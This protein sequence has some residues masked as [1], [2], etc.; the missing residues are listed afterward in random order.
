LVTGVRSNRE[1]PEV[2]S[3]GEG[4]ALGATK[5]LPFDNTNL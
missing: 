4:G 2:V 1:N 3:N 5:A